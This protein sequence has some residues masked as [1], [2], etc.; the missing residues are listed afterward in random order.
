MKA[1][2]HHTYYTASLLLHEEPTT[3]LCKASISH[4]GDRIYLLSA[5]S[6]DLTTPDV[7]RLYATYDAI[8]TSHPPVDWF[9]NY[10]SHSH[11]TDQLLSSLQNGTAI[12]VSDGSYYP[13]S[14]I[15]SCGWIIAS[16]NG[17]EWIQGGGIIPGDKKYQCSHRSEL[18]GQVGIVSFLH[19]ILLPPSTK[20]PITHITTICDG[21]SALNQVG[22]SGHLIKVKHKHAD[23]VSLLSSLWQLSGY[24]HT[25]EHIKAHQDDLYG[26]LTLKA[27]LN[28]KMDALAKHIAMVQISSQQLYT[29]FTPTNLGFGTVTCHGHWISSKM[30]QNMYHHV[31]QANLLNKLAGALNINV[32]LLHD[33]INW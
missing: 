21:L 9:M 4:M 28:C 13:D 31:V 17:G 2:C 3:S 7:T 5:S 11:S 10:I 23:L 12:A 15:G 22:L 25:K 14:Q 27:S 16:M 1:N 26:P 6:L 24:S 32:S 18:G 29:S 19:S 30:Q 20:P 8:T 33:W